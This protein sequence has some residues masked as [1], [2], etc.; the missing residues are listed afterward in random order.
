[1]LSPVAQE[2]ITMYETL[3][4]TVEQIA[5]DTELEVPSIKAILFQSSSLYRQD[6]KADDKLQFTETEAEEAKRIILN[7][8]RYTGDEHLQFKAARYVLDCKTNR[9]E[10]GTQLKHTTFNV[11]SFNEQMQRALAAQRKTEEKAIE[12]S[13]AKQLVDAA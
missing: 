10:A 13:A 7:I 9:I 12:I 4:M 11:I 5:A 2:I 8:A 3:G 1:M 6:A